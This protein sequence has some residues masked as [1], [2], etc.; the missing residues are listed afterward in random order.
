MNPFPKESEFIKQMH[1]RDRSFTL[2]QFKQTATNVLRCRAVEEFVGALRLWTWSSYGCHVQ[3]RSMP[4]VQSLRALPVHLSWCREGTRS[5]IEQTK[6]Q[7]QRWRSFAQVVLLPQ[8]Y[9]TQRLWLLQTEGTQAAG[10]IFASLTTADR[11]RVADIGS[12]HIP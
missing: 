1:H 10:C 7:T 6:G 2:D 5:Q 12:S 4:S 8:T 11:A 9:L 3:Q